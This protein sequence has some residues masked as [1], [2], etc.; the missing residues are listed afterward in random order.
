MSPTPRLKT[1]ANILYN[2]LRISMTSITP[3]ADRHAGPLQRRK[4]QLLL[5]SSR[6][7]TASQRSASPSASTELDINLADEQL[8]ADYFRD[9]LVASAS[10]PNIN[11][12]VLWGFWE[13]QHWRHDAALFRKG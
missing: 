8:Q 1:T 13:S 6:S 4:P 5:N 9:F 3:S 7:T 2:Q 10:H 12:I 11:G